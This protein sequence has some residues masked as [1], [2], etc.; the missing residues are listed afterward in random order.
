MRIGQIGCE[1]Q[2][3]PI[4]N[5][6]LH[7][8]GFVWL[9]A[10]NQRAFRIGKR[11]LLHCF[12]RNADGTTQVDSRIDRL[13][14]SSRATPLDACARVVDCPQLRRC[15]QRTQVSLKLMIIRVNLQ[16]LYRRQNLYQ[17]KLSEQIYFSLTLFLHNIYIIGCAQNTLAMLSLSKLRNCTCIHIEIL[18]SYPSLQTACCLKQNTIK[19]RVR[20]KIDLNLQ[21]LFQ[22]TDT[23]P[24]RKKDQRWVI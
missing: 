24:Q 2:N 14:R 4:Q 13:A 7:H 9:R 5:A 12:L 21:V 23:L 1:R 15:A 8:Q 3:P 10:C 16:F 11:Q 19:Q 20:T 6:E 17:R 22:Q 18:S